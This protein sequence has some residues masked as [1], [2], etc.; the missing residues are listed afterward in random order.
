MTNEQDLQ[1]DTAMKPTRWVTDPAH[2]AVHFSVR[3]M[4]FARVRGRFRDFEATLHL[5]EADLSGSRVEAV[6]QAAGIDTSADD[7]DQHLRSGDFLDA[8]QYP[9][10]RFQST[11][12][13]PVGDNKARVTGGLTIRGVT[14]EMTLDVE[15]LGTGP[16]PWGNTR[17]AYQAETTIDRKAYGLSWNQALETGGVLVGDKIKIEIEV[18]LVKQEA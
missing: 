16:D 8:E 15:H 11:R 6:I 7:R 2:S 3:H 10:L 17:S 5:D 13:E 14:K 12:V 4:M 9:T 1:T 18:Q